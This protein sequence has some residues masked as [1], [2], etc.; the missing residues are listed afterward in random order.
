MGQVGE[1]FFIEAGGIRVQGCEVA[2]DVGSALFDDP[3]AGGHSLGYPFGGVTQPERGECLFDPGPH[4]R[5][6]VHRD[7]EGVFVNDLDA[8]WP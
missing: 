7:I 8:V 6:A 5:A 1:P 4:F 2:G 3:Y